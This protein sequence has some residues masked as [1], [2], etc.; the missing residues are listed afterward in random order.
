MSV[1]THF[2]CP[3]ECINITLNNVLDIADCLGGNTDYC[4]NPLTPVTTVVNKFTSCALQGI[5]KYGSTDGILSALQGV[6]A[7]L[8]N[9]LGLSDVV[10]ST[11]TSGPWLATSETCKD[12]IHINTGDIGLLGK[13][14]DDLAV[15]CQGG[16]VA[17]DDVYQELFETLECLLNTLSKRDLRKI[18]LGQICT[19]VEGFEELDIGIDIVTLLTSSATG[20]LGGITCG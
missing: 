2:P 12:P 18:A 20:L 3:T 6:G 19:I 7:I 11:T 9:S 5:I 10:P 16:E 13:C 4:D 14:V 8:L 17:E 15:L 1:K